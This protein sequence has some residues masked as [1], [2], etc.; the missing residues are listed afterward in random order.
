MVSMTSLLIGCGNLGK[1]ILDGFQKNKKVY[2]LDNNL[3]INK[4]L[5]ESIEKSNS[6]NL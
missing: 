6:V 2:V 4:R 1:I 5:L 3:K